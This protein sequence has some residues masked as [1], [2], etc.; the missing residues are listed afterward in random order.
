MQTHKLSAFVLFD[1]LHIH[2]H[3]TKPNEQK[4]TSRKT[5]SHIRKIIKNFTQCALLP[6][7]TLLSM[8]QS[9]KQRF[10]SFASIL[11]FNTFDIY[12]LHS[13]RYFK[14]EIPCLK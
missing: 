10:V 14:A 4:K 6:D 2:I 12:R 8:R 1:S 11:L 3:K 9:Q 13:D 5:N 7:A